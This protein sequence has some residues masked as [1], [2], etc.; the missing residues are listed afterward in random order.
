MH[1]AEEGVSRFSQ[2][3]LTLEVGFFFA[4]FQTKGANTKSWRIDKPFLQEL[5][6]LTKAAV[7]EIEDR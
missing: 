7:G 1:F 3:N 5:V 6:A 2:Y 4:H